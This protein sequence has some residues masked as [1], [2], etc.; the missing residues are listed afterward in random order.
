MAHMIE[1]ADSHNGLLTV[2]LPMLL[3]EIGAE[4]ANLNWSFLYLSATG[5]LGEGKSIVDFE[6]NIS[7]SSNGFCLE[8]Q[9]LNS[10]SHKFEQVFDTLIIGS[11]SKNSI[12][13]YTD[14]E[15]LYSNYAVVLDLFDGAY[16]RV[17]SE[18]ESLIKNLGNKFFD[19]K[20]SR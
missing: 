10:L 17:Y 7:N 9:E 6:D 11:V 4:G 13:K 1:I 18:N 14:D 5:D 3:D 12:Q 8:W 16:W 15:D 20:F 19:I 2:T